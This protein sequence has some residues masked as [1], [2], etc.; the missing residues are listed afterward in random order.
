MAVGAHRW[1]RLGRTLGSLVPFCSGLL[2]GYVLSIPRDL[3]AWGL[4][5][6]VAGFGA[7]FLLSSL[8][9]E[10][11]HVAAIRL[12]GSRPTAIHLLGPPDRVAFHVGSLRVGLGIS[13]PGSEVEYPGDGLSVLH[14]ALIAAAG[15]AADLVAAPLLLL[16][17]IAR[18]AAVFSA[19]TMAA[20]G[21]ANLVP[22]KTADGQL[23]D[24]VVLIRARARSRVSADIRELLAAP[25]WSLRPDAASRLVS[26]WVL[27]VPEAETCLE[28]LPGGRD[29]L[30]RLYAQD[31]PLE[32]WPEPG[33]LNIVHVLSRKV[34]ARPDGP[35]GL[36]DIAG[37]RVEWVLGQVDR[38][39]RNARPKPRDVR[40]TLAVI[41]LRQGRA[42]DVG[43][44][45]ADALAADLDGDV[46]ASVLATVAMAKHQLGLPVSARQVLR[47]ALAL[48]PGAEL[49][50][51]A[52][53]L[54]YDTAAPPAR[55]AA[56]QRRS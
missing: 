6:L 45:C 16:V 41:R 22:A 48:D 37:T 49:V 44:L 17:P 27:D 28:R 25:D 29:T 24:G 31:W 23:S 1:L 4:M 5:A 14:D 50:A 55:Y 34:V 30:L 33:L 40:H 3:G 21:L 43:R 42:A 7:V 9:H 19:V 2:A 18:W 20:Y 52:V 54:L 56:A 38:L 15:P 47:E 10:L 26:G 46:R 12:A 39:G 53:G 32:Q 35:A 36:A 13:R 11:G 8:V 51:E